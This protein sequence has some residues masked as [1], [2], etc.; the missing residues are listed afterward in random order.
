MDIE[1]IREWLKDNRNRT[2]DDVVDSMTDEECIGE[3]DYMMSL[4]FS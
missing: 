3:Y 2:K 4:L 1:F